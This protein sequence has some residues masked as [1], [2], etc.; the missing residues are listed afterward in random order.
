M[1]K[2]NNL[3]YLRGVCQYLL[4]CNK[5]AEYFPSGVF[6]H[7]CGVSGCGFGRLD[8]RATHTPGVFS[9]GESLLGN[10]AV[11][12]PVRLT[13]A[14]AAAKGECVRKRRI[15]SLEYLL[16]RYT[17]LLHWNGLYKVVKVRAP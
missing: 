13:Y 8:I 11:S 10:G 4:P 14:Y 9:V 7:T 17:E 15:L 6:T 12:V 5:G 2:D 16:D 1:F 3:H